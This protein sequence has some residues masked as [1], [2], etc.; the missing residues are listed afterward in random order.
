MFHFRLRSLSRGGDLQEYV[1]NNYA[2]GNAKIT[3]DGPD[4]VPP[5]AEPDNLVTINPVQMSAEHF[6][7]N[8]EMPWILVAIALLPTSV[9]LDLRCTAKGQMVHLPHLP[10]LKPPSTG[11]P[12]PI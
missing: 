12:T 6:P 11:S 1:H 4:E 10:G 8:A 5:C 9:G 7:V 3:L 2:N